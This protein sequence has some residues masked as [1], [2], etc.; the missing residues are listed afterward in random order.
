MNPLA[1]RLGITAVLLAVLFGVGRL[2]CTTQ[3]VEE[4]P[5]T[6]APLLNPVVT[7]RLMSV[8][9]RASVPL[10][11]SGHWTLRD[12]DKPDAPPLLERSGYLAGLLHSDP[13]G[14]QFDAYRG[15]RDHITIEGSGDKALRI[16][17]DYYPGKLHVRLDRER[18]GAVKG[19]LL[20]L[21]IPLEDYVLGVVCGEMRSQAK[22]GQQAL[23]AQAI[24][25]RT[26]ALHKLQTKDSVRD[27][28]FDQVFRGLDFVT[29][30]AEE[31][32]AATRGQVLAFED[33]L[34]PAYFHR[35]CG[36][37]TADAAEAGFHRQEIQPLSGVMDSGCRS[38]RGIWE[39]T[40]PATQLDDL[41][42]RYK[43]GAWLQGISTIRRDASGRLLE[44]RLLGETEHKDLLAEQMRAALSLP[45]VQLVDVRVLAD[46]AAVFRGHGYG[47]G[48]GLCQ[49]GTLR[50][51]RS[52][53]SCEEILQHYYPG[54]ALVP[55]T[56]DL[57]HL[58]PPR[59]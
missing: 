9:G 54:S 29:T 18:S 10:E 21:E 53:S 42:K 39:R 51:S 45:S 59:P 11:L 6:V 24:A 13:S 41:A 35:N 14:P 58:L 32:V 20:S 55:L 38:P 7:V 52:G 46:G 44:I 31:A 1:R 28:T 15:G 22:G 17:H 2:S 34:V 50:M 36:G 23:R 8:S 33:A 47:H 43:L 37:G 57:E 40:I 12:G 25:A 26:Y 3:E 30:Q 56:S 5:L 16:V 27:D 49:E 19:L 48:V 4:H